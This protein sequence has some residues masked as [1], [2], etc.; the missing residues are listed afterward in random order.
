MEFHFLPHLKC[1]FLRSS[2]NDYEEGFLNERFHD[3]AKAH[4]FKA[5][6]EPFRER[7]QRYRVELP[8]IE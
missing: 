4:V 5:R 8:R 1:Y 2:P 6:A 7:L 3:T